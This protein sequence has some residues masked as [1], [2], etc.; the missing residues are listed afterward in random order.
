MTTSKQR[1]RLLRRVI[2]EEL[3]HTP[4]GYMQPQE[5]IENSTRLSLCPAPTDAELDDAFRNLEADALIHRE[6]DR[7]GVKR[8]CITSLGRAALED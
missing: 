2:L 3:T 1:A 7:L 6:V 4:R 8:W 5:A